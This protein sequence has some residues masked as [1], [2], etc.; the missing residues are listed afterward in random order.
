MAD[1]QPYLDLV[2]S[3]HNDKPNFMATLSV[4]LQGAVSGRDVIASMVE[5][6]DLD[7]AV[8]AQL[9]AVGEWVGQTRY[10]SLPITGVYFSFDT[11]GVGFNEGTWQG[12]F[13]PITG[14]TALPD[15]AYRTLLRAV[16]ASNQWDGSIPEAYE[17]WDILFAGTGSWIII[18]DH[19][20]MSMTFGLLGPAPDAV[21]F[22]LLTGGYLA[23]KPAGVRINNYVIP[24]VPNT[25][26]FGFDSDTD[27]V[28]GFDDAS[29]GEFIPA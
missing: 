14:L 20:D 17:A 25:P 3:E 16:I 26:L 4:L 9:D 19:Q 10:L 6:F 29:W 1:I 28:G 21:T 7:T 27:S 12:P 24:T 11:A 13:D 8:G 23:L 22:A 15:D 5:K 2:T 18:I